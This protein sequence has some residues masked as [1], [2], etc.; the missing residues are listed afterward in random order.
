MISSD[1]IDRVLGALDPAEVI[2]LTAALVRINSVFDPEAGTSE[3][4]AAE[5]VARW[6]ERRGFEVLVEEAAPRRPNVVV[7]HR[8][9]PGGKR[10]LMFEGHTDVVTAGDPAAWRHPPFSAAIV[11]RRMY[12]R[13][14]NDTK[15]NLAAMLCA[16]A[17]LRRAAV[18]LHGDILGGVLCDE[19]GAMTGVQ[20]FIRRGHADR[21]SAAVICE[22]QD[23]LICTSQKGA[24]RA[25]YTVTGRMCHGAMPLSGLNPAPAVAE[26][27]RGLQRLE[28]EACRAL[29]RDPDLNWPSFTPTVIQAPPEGP[30]QLNVVPAR[31]VVLVDVRTIPQQSHPAIVES[32][33]NLAAETKRRVREAT[34]AHDRELGV[35]RDPELA[36]DLEILSDRP[37]TRTDRE[38]PVVRAAAWATQVVTGREPVYGGVPGAT[39]GTFLSAWKGIPIVTLGAG[40]REVPHQVDEWVDLDQ[41]VETA[42]IYALT[43]LAY[44]GSPQP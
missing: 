33:K 44:L 43:A 20:D 6:A 39:D 21:V 24:V 13:G 34:L 1:R 31:A 15:G 18:P 22:P 3:Q 19:E 8:G 14:T 32:L 11:G 36:V 17:A 5:F 28:E 7:T 30:A 26:I 37:C 23:G 29:G 10:T 16:M 38:E 41:L 35:T 9:S 40:D 27:I 12:G 4:E 42:R 25:R 2:E